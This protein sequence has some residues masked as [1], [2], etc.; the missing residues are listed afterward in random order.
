MGDVYV[1]RQLQA[2]QLATNLRA[3]IINDVVSTASEKSIFIYTPFSRP[4][5]KGVQDISCELF[6][7]IFHLFIYCSNLA[8]RVYMYNYCSLTQSVPI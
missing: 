8:N 5:K 7:F 6:L 4:R 1:F 3:K 2:Q